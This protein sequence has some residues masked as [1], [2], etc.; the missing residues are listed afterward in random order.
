MTSFFIAA[1][2]IAWMSFIGAW[3]RGGRVERLAATVL[4]CD[5]VLSSFFSRLPLSHAFEISTSVEILTT[6]I[7]LWLAAQEDRW[8]LLAAAAALV[9][10]SLTGAMGL[11]HPGV[12]HYAAASG[13][14]G[15][16]IVVYLSLLAGVGERWLAGEAPVFRGGRK[17]TR[18]TA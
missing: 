2:I 4:V 8:W 18:Q 15:F 5:Y 14:I 1:Q 3:W 6:L 7:F 17:W 9:L 12:S 11:V 13:Q 16:W 10:C